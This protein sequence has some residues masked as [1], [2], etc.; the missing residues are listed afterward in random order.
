MAKFPDSV[1]HY[2][3]SQLTYILKEIIGCNSTL[4]AFLT[5]KV[6]DI[7][8]TLSTLKF[9]KPL[10]VI[11]QF[12]L[13]NDSLGFGTLKLFRHWALHNGMHNENEQLDIEKKQLE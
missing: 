6:S 5:L 8:G 13:V 1:I 2:E 12:P 7:E 4:Y 9:L 10:E 3:A 11:E